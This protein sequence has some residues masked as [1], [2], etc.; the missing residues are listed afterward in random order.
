MT[1]FGGKGEAL[2]NVLDIAPLNALAE[3]ASRRISDP[4]IAKRYQKLAADRV[5]ANP[6]SFRPATAAELSVA[7]AWA[8]AAA[9]RG[10]TISV[11]RSNGAMAARLHTVARHINDAVRLA[12]MDANADSEHST[13]IEDAR[14][15]IAKFGRVN[16]SDA[17]LKATKFA[18]ALAAWEGNADTRDVCED[19]SLVL[20]SGRIWRR[21]TSVA[22]LRKIGR[23]FSNCLARTSRVSSYGA[24]LARGTA[25][26]WVLRDLEGGGHMVACAPAPLAMRFTEVKGPRN[27]PIS[28]DHP[29]LLQLGVALGVRPSPPPRPP[30][31][32]RPRFGDTPTRLLALIEELQQPRRCTLCQP[33]QAG[34]TLSERLRRSGAAH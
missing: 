9:E 23:E 11:F 17:A 22:Q 21:I 15:F 7:P 26:F 14:R 5:R 19:Q 6:R 30:L 10:E 13:T 3:R 12:A 28:P 25:Q 8:Q 33:R 2:P 32:P 31:P 34:L 16:F 24:M 1:C 27:A 4:A 18:H 29:D 20:L